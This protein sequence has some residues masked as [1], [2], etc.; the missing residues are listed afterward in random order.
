[1]EDISDAAKEIIRELIA[2][3]EEAKNVGC[4]D[5]LDCCGD[6]GNFWYDAIE[7][8]KNALK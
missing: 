3:M 8:G 2:A 1:M 4:V 5:H 7:N 6:G